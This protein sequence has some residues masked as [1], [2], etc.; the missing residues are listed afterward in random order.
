MSWGYNKLE[1]FQQEKI[2]PKNVSSKIWLG[3]SCNEDRC[4]PY[5]WIF[6]FSHHSI[7]WYL[8]AR[9]HYLTRKL[10]LLTIERKTISSPTPVEV[11]TLGPPAEDWLTRGAA[12]WTADTDRFMQLELQS[13]AHISIYL[14][15]GRFSISYYK[16]H[17]NHSVRSIHGDEGGWQGAEQLIQ[18]GSCS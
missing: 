4:R 9:P 1:S 16:T 14:S 6:H 15:L 13:Q 8:L 5:L 18:T 3:L 2:L 17:P 11:F 12:S 10:S 7:T